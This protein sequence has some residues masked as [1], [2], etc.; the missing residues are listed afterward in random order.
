MNSR[1]KLLPVILSCG[2]ALLAVGIG[3]DWPAWLLVLMGVTTLS[4]VG[5]VLVL[6]PPSPV[7]F[8]RGPQGAARPPQTAPAPPPAPAAP[9]EPPFHQ[10]QVD[11]VQLPSA[12]EGYDF[13][14]SATVLWR[15]VRGYANG[16][17][18]NLAVMHLLTR[19]RTV[20]SGERPE[21]EDFVRHLLGGIL[22]FPCQ[23][24]GNQVITRGADI[25]LT[26]AAADRE[27][28]QKVADLRKSQDL[29]ER[30]RAYERRKRAYLGDEVLKTPG[31]AVVWWLARHDD[32]VEQTV[33]MIGP[34]AQISAAANDTELPEHLRHLIAWHPAPD[35]NGHPGDPGT[36]GP[37]PGP[38]TAGPWDGPFTAPGAATPD[39][40]PADHLSGL[41]TDLGLTEDSDTRTVLVHRII[42]QMKDIGRHEEAERIRREFMP[43]RRS[44]D[45]TP[46]TTGDQGSATA[47]EPPYSACSAAYAAGPSSPA[48]GRPAYA[49]GPASSATERAPYAAAPS[50]SA[51][52]RWPYAAGP[53]PS[54]TEQPAYVA[55]PS[56]IEVSHPTAEPS[57]AT[58]F[59]PPA[60]SAH[61][62]RPPAHEQGDGRGGH[63]TNRTATEEAVTFTNP[64]AWPPAAPESAPAA[65]WHH[66]AVD[67][68][69]GAGA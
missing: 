7:R 56:G 26:L 15:P 20:T 9:A 46:P 36:Y 24:Q 65:E 23:D 8:H 42:R 39:D 4:G 35:P 68:H 54:T 17:L 10:R 31:S 57:H 58:A 48:S 61:P 30:E 27:R 53:T 33:G 28:L 69:E 43:P 60:P 41:L 32:K 12:L 51:A 14:F 37:A 21:R 25:R 64:P 62:D 11:N 44:A 40:A 45:R 3:L 38:G 19:A 6:T 5:L 67:P 59:E 49:A 50:P 22:G 55:G 34:L 13:L 2:L 18:A 1:S 29:W 47:T 63:H 52:G 66:P 16:D